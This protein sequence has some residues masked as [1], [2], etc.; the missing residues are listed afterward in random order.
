MV[1][2]HLGS[3]HIAQTRLLVLLSSGVHRTI[4]YTT[5]SENATNQ[6]TLSNRWSLVWKPVLYWLLSSISTFSLTQR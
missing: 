5:T 6:H 1:M 2:F 3:K 4:Q